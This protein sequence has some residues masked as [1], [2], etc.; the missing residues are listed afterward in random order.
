M[1][2]EDVVWI[3][4][5]PKSGNTWV[6]QV[7]KVAAETHGFPRNASMDAHELEKSAEEI[8]EFPKVKVSRNGCAVL[9]TH[10]QCDA[11]GRAHPSLER[12]RPV[13]SIYVRRNP[14]DVLLSY[15]NFSRIQYFNRKGKGEH[16]RKGLFRTLLGM[17]DVPDYQAWRGESL[18]SLPTK[19]LDHALDYFS[20]SGMLI[21]TLSHFGSWLDHNEVWQK[22]QVD[23]KLL[24]YYEDCIQNLEAFSVLGTMFDFSDDEIRTAVRTRNDIT[25][26]AREA[27]SGK[28]DNKIF[29]NKM[30]SFY[31]VKYFSMAAISR[32]MVRHGDKLE[33][34]GYVNLPLH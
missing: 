8:P 28:P 26:T 20:E 15:I 7:L 22:A 14:L 21:P 27:R 30:T 2:I 32:F 33:S 25:N 5:Y 13:G 18:D 24:I 19:L 1:T 3:P 17:K 9:K 23:N 34:L 31:Y 12:L 4:S 11:T 10:N 6:H 16:Y 29:Y